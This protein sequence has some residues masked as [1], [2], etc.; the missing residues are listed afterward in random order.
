MMSRIWSLV[1]FRITTVNTPKSKPFISMNL[2]PFEITMIFYVPFF[3]WHHRTCDHCLSSSRSWLP[4]A[5]HIRRHASSIYGHG[6]NLHASLSPLPMRPAS[7][8]LSRR[9]TIISFSRSWNSICQQKRTSSSSTWLSR[10]TS[11][12]ASVN[13]FLRAWPHKTGQ[14]PWTSCIFLSR[15]LLTCLNTHPH[16]QRPSIVSTPVCFKYLTI[17]HQTD[18]CLV[19][20]EKIF[21][22]LDLHRDDS[23]WGVV[24][25]GLDVVDHFMSLLEKALDEQY[26]FDPNSFGGASQTEEA[27]LVSRA[28]IHAMALAHSL[29]SY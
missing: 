2:L 11:A 3:G 12:E 21:T 17:P 25:V 7:I 9:G 8:D 4:L 28:L 24:E 26:S 13:M 27:L 5:A 14:L 23:C 20:L 29:C 22:K 18:R 6:I 16:C 1:H 15:L 19:P 10:K